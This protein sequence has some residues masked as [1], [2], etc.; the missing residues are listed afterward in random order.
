MLLVVDDD[1]SVVHSL[2]FQELIVQA[3]VEHLAF[4]RS[5]ADHVCEFRQF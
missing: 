1:L 2:R 3:Y 5:L 4:I